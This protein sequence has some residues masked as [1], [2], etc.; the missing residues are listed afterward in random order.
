MNV[1]IFLATDLGFVEHQAM[2]HVPV[3]ADVVQV[4]A[5]G[6]EH[7]HA[8]VAVPERCCVT[9]SRALISVLLLPVSHEHQS[10]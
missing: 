10:C 1:Q 4:L 8:A 7:G 9:L 2:D 6:G 5:L 3:A